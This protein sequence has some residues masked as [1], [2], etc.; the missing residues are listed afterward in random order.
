MSAVAEAFYIICDPNRADDIRVEEIE[1]PFF[2]AADAIARAITSASAECNSVGNAVG[3]ATAKATATAWASAT[4]EAHAVAY[5]EAFNGCAANGSCNKQAV[6]SA[7]ASA[8]NLASS[9]IELTADAYARAEVEVCVRGTQSASAEA[10]SSCFAKSWAKVSTQAIA[11][12]TVSGQCK[13]P[14]AEVFVEAVTNFKYTVVESCSETKATTGNGEADPGGGSADA[15][16]LFALRLVLA[17][18]CSPEFALQ[19]EMSIVF[20]ITLLLMLSRTSFL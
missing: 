7:T 18:P 12:A 8:E 15:V 4:A 6:A 10:M 3:C 1:G 19:S 17:F 11:M 13:I 16:R 9:F 5:A 20:E 2:A 14:K